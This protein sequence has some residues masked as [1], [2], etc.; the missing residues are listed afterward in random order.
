MFLE[1]LRKNV[2]DLEQQRMA[3]TKGDELKG[4]AKTKDAAIALNLGIEARSVCRG[5]GRLQIWGQYK[6]IVINMLQPGRG[7]VHFS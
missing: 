5:S 7:A 4:G 3:E 6:S 1:H 2:I